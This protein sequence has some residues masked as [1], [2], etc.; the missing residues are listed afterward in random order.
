MLIQV[1]EEKG[2]PRESQDNRVYFYLVHDNWDDFH[3]KTSYQLY[4]SGRFTKDR[5]P[6]LIGLVKILKRNQKEGDQL[7]LR[8]GLLEALPANYC[9]LGQSLDYYQRI[10][11]LEVNIRNQLIESLRDIALNLEI[12]EDFSAEKGLRASL[13]RDFAANDDI[14]ALAPMLI[15]REFHK[16]PSLDLHFTFKT[17][18]MEQPITFDFD[19]PEY[20][21]SE[22]LPN[23]IAVL[24]GRNGSGKS[25]F[26]AKM[27]R[28]VFAS[29][30]DRKTSGL[31]QVGELTP[32]GLG[33][34]RIINLA[35]NAFDSFHV[36]G[37]HIQEKEQIAKD[38]KMGE[39]RYIFCG[40]RDI[41]AELKSQLPFFHPDPDGRL[42]V[43][44]ILK[45]R[46]MDTVLKSSHQLGV[47]FFTCLEGI[48]NSNRRENLERVFNI[49]IEESS[50]NSA[51]PLD[52]FDL[53]KKAIDFFNELSTGHKFVLHSLISVVWYIQPRSL[54]LFDEPE[55]HLHP[56]LLAVLMKALRNVI[57]EMNGFMI[58][59]T[60]SP[61]VVQETLSKHVFIIRREGDFLKINKPS[62]QT[63]GENI[64]IIT[65]H[66]FGLST[67][68]TD[69]HEVLENIVATYTYREKNFNKE[70]IL[71]E[72]ESLFDGNLSMQARAFV[73]S[74]LSERQN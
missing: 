44:D 51:I 71:A 57:V 74:K 6:G 70:K 73:L 23:R 54:L 31:K 4:V 5:T 72:I 55:N 43:A 16:L 68:I 52:I 25:S 65:S 48:K 9:S 24:I 40:V 58:V 34:P 33:F 17:S 45:D 37:I 22:S 38:V 29:T 35:Y 50:M 49:L 32:V 62:I 53:G 11:E 3:F 64:G 61:V 69:Y 36:P 8:G 67:D 30:T 41:A 19:S 28:I 7:Q 20:G 12:R 10:A 66:V 39:G 2:T 63:F 60:H 26:L 18:G 14:F 1:I 47:E 13:M 21:F 46:Q 15:S 56:P 42:S 59:A 27:S